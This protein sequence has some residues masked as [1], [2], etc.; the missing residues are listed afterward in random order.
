MWVA[1]ESSKLLCLLP[2]DFVPVVVVS[3]DM[4]LM[5]T[6]CLQRG[7][8]DVPGSDRT[9]ARGNGG[10]EHLLFRFVVLLPPILSTN[11]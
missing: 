5:V 8:G 3:M 9:G 6:M 7:I 4:K 2:G 10:T 11:V 1:P